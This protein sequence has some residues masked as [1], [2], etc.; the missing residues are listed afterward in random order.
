MFGWSDDPAR[1]A[2]GSL[3]VVESLLDSVYVV[4]RLW[5]GWPP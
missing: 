5:H 1:T 2:P 3:H 4:A